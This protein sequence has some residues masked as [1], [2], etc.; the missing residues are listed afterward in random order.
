MTE[1]VQHREPFAGAVPPQQDHCGEDRDP[2]ES[3]GKEQPRRTGQERAREWI[4]LLGQGVVASPVIG[5]LSREGEAD[6]GREGREHQQ[7]ESPA[8]RD[9][10]G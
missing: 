1:R 6:I 9:H 10:K 8:R 4:S 2:D 7:D 3:S 5:V